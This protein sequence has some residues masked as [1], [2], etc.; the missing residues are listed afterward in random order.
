MDVGDIDKDIYEEIGK[1]GRGKK[2]KKK[3]KERKIGK[4]VGKVVGGN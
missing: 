4:C 2:K 3:K 1:I